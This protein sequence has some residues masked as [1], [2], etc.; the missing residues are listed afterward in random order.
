MT[1]II[2]M[3]STLDIIT[4][5]LCEITNI[6][7]AYEAPIKFKSGKIYFSHINTKIYSRKVNSSRI[8]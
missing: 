1:T 6:P 7:N 4:K 2:Q 5:L 8:C 3:D